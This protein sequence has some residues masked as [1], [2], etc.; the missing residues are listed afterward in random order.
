M[1]DSAGEE[2]LRAAARDAAAAAEAARLARLRALLLAEDRTAMAQ[3]AARLEEVAGS[4]RDPA[5]FRQAMA[6]NLVEA[7]REARDQRG[8]ALAST[9]APLVGGAIRTEIR[10]SRHEMAEALRPIA[11]RMVKA[12]VADNFAQLLENVNARLDSLTSAQG[13]SLRLRALA[14]GRSVSELALAQLA[15]RGVSRIL[16]IDRRS[17]GLIAQWPQEA[18][19]AK[20][21]MIGGM[22]AAILSFSEDALGSADSESEL[23]SL[24]L[25]GSLLRLHARALWILAFETEGAFSAESSALMDEVAAKFLDKRGED[26]PEEA[27]DPDTLTPLARDLIAATKGAEAK[28]RGRLKGAFLGGAILL[29]LAGLWGWKAWTSHLRD[30][31]LARVSAELRAD[32]ELAAA[33]LDASWIGREAIEAR[34]VLPFGADGEALEARLAAAAGEGFPVRVRFAHGSSAEIHQAAE[35]RLVGLSE[36][37]RDEAMRAAGEAARNGAALTQMRLQIAA[38]QEEIAALN[39]ALDSSAAGAQGLRAQIAALSPTVETLRAPESRLRLWA[40]RTAV[41]LPDAAH[42]DSAVNLDALDE[43]ADILRQSG[44]SLPRLRIVG[45]ADRTGRAELNERL[46]VERAQTIAEELIRR[47]APAD[48]LLIAGRLEA[49]DLA[50]H[51]GPGSRNRRVQFELAFPGE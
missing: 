41:F 49:A 26:S 47:G 9:I 48:R 15:G 29:G 10:N 50:P 24:D 21:E 3:L 51:H 45:F 32:P 33:P 8:K 1:A 13:W 4:A 31:A 43:A 40:S 12:A 16:L 38:A 34:G 39:R 28:S 22:I 2:R 46:A 44:A 37:A 5:A 23:R 20:S 14:T 18:D 27:A 11:G 30:E 36:E 35:A 6:E 17:G 19:D 42:L 7:M 25:N